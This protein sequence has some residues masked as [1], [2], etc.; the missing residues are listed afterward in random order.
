MKFFKTLFLLLLLTNVVASCKKTR[1]CTD[2][3]ALNYN[4]D[5]RKDDHS[6]Y[7]YWVGQEYQGG[8]IFYV[9]QTGKHGLIALPFDLATAPW[10][11]QGTLLST[12]S[13]VG[14][15]ASNTEVIA[16]ACGASSAASI[17][18]DLD[19]LG[20]DDWYLPSLQE[21]KGLN[22]T[23]GVMGE[24]QLGSG[25]YWTSTE[26]DIDNAWTIMMTNITPVSVS[27]T[28]SYSV[29]PIRSF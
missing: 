26:I 17:C 16:L 28:A 13:N 25:Y 20:Y 27:K 18:Y 22:E 10:G 4:P 29:R 14:T 19:T 11:C 3:E 15:G 8:K 24:V 2:A 21:L 9:D 6:C 1:G 7:Y 23:L 12:A 5:A